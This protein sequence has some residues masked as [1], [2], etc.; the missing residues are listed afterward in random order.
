MI[1]KIR[2]KIHTL[3]NTSGLGL[4]GGDG[5]AM[6]SLASVQEQGS[7]RV[8][9]HWATGL[10]N[11]LPSF[12]FLSGHFLPSFLPMYVCMYLAIYHLLTFPA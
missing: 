6:L 4:L 12:L 11:F 8:S 2:K 3:G 5:Q 1:E 7:C 9:S 10:C